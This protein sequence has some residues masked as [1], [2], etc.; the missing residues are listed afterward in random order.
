MVLGCAWAACE[1]RGSLFS[2]AGISCKARSTTRSHGLLATL[3]GR[4]GAG[5]GHHPGLPGPGPRNRWRHRSRG[6]WA[7][8]L[9]LARAGCACM[10]GRVRCFEGRVLRP[11][12][13]RWKSTTAAAMRPPAC[14]GDWRDN[15]RDVDCALV[16]QARP[17]HHHPAPHRWVGSL[18]ACPG[19]VASWDAV[20]RPMPAQVGALHPPRA[21]LALPA[22]RRRLYCKHAG[23]GG[24]RRGGDCEAG[25]GGAPRPAGDLT[26]L[27]KGK[28]WQQR[29]P[30]LSPGPPRAVRTPSALAGCQDATCA[31]TALQDQ[32]PTADGSPNVPISV[33]WQAPQVRSTAASHACRTCSCPMPSNDE[34]PSPL[35]P[36]PAV[37]V[38]WGQRA[39]GG[40]RLAGTVLLAG[41]QTAYSWP[42]WAQSCMHVRLHVGTGENSSMPW[43]LHPSKLCSMHRGHP[44][45]VNTQTAGPRRHALLLLRAAS[46]VHGARQLRGGRP[47]GH[48]AGAGCGRSCRLAGS[49][50]G[51]AGAQPRRTGQQGGAICCSPDHAEAAGHP[52]CP[53]THAGCRP[54]ARRAAGRAGLP[55]TSTRGTLTTSSGR[56][57]C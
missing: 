20:V 51:R 7:G 15:L 23:H 49:R 17:P 4:A 16:C 35:L 1:S 21:A 45:Q 24:C 46:G 56:C 12:S 14:S 22:S 19:G 26:R 27:G 30:A 42:A 11:A 18:P 41:K 37:R 6:G 8:G 32:D 47:G 25:R 33:W 28:A 52:S 31:C 43:A 13:S 10:G 39:A 5:H 40:G 2:E 29:L 55:G 53:P 3:P 9:G 38:H 54:S 48:T 57:W 36:A 44:A 50:G 34:R